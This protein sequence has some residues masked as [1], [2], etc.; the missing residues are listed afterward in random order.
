MPRY[1]ITHSLLSSWLY[2]IKGNPYED[3]TTERDPYAEFMAVLRREPTPT[4]EAMQKGIDFENLV[5]DIVN[6]CGDPNN[7]WYE[8]AAKIASIVKGGPLQVPAKR[9]IEVNGMKILLYGRLDALKAGII[10]DIKFSPGYERGKYIDSTQHPTYFEIVPEATAF[11]YLVSN[12]TDVWTEPYRREDTRSIIPII[13]EFLDWLY[14][15]GLMPLY[16]Q[17][18]QAAA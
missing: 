5:T 1:M 4:T 14:S 8:A 15:V 7:G 10:R 3:A 13:S 9:E 2:A 17:K 11:E 12:G 6:G 18:W 16:Q